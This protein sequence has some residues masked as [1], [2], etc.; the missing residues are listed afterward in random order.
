[1]VEIGVR[2]GKFFKISQDIVFMKGN[3]SSKEQSQKDIT[4]IMVGYFLKLYL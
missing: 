1:M 4:H 2:E 3:L